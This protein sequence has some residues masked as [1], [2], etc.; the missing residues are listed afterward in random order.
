MSRPAYR[1]GK[2]RQDPASARSRA[3]RHLAAAG[4][5]LATALVLL[6]SVGRAALADGFA[7]AVRLGPGVNILGYD[8]IWE[9]HADSPF[10]ER[11]LDLIRE[12]GFRHVRI[13]LHAFKYMDSSGDL[14]P[15]VVARLD[16]VIDRVIAHDLVPVLDEHDFH[17]CQSNPA[18]CDARLSAFWGQMSRH[19]SGKAPSMLF[20]LLNEPGGSMT[21]ASWNDLAQ[22]LLGRIRE[23]D[24]A[25]TV[26]VAA[27]NTES[28]TELDKLVLPASDRNVILTFHYYKPFKFTHQGAPWSQK[29]SNVRN[30]VW[31]DDADKQQLRTDF[32]RIEEIARQQGRPVYLGEFGVLETADI[33]S[34]TSYLSWITQEANG[35]RWPWAYWQFD[36]DF[37]L[38]D[39][40][41][42]RWVS[43]VLKALK[44]HPG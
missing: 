16:R 29:M 36:H 42:E 18:G 7:A 9:G 10:K 14:N 19:Y 26:I 13:N 40:S 38:F 17:F 41:K 32:D 43:P 20:E 37:A 12:A 1:S 4:T 6:L 35:R 33:N 5:S 21:A 31:G 23:V 39:T 8:G 24:P 27:L 3:R 34:R 44:M 22:R 25:R 2:R 15:L 11:Y 30:V 28:P